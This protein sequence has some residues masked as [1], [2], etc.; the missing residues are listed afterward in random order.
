M[1]EHRPGW[2]ERREVDYLVFGS[3]MYGRYFDEPERYLGQKALYERLF[4]SF[5][6]VAQFEDSRNEVLIFRNPD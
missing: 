6:L 1:I 5:D 4:R 2:Y 3:R